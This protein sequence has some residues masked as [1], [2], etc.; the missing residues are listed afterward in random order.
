MPCQNSWDRLYHEQPGYIN[1][2]QQNNEWRQPYQQERDDYVPSSSGSHYQDD[3]YGN[4]YE[5]GSYGDDAYQLYYQKPGANGYTRC[6]S[7]EPY[8]NG[9][10]DGDDYAYEN[11]VRIPK[12][13]PKEHTLYW[14]YMYTKTHLWMVRPPSGNSKHTSPQKQYSNSSRPRNSLGG[15]TGQHYNAQQHLSGISQSV[16]FPYKPQHGVN[17]PGV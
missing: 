11:G 12:V 8:S 6:A 1:G 3:Y 5:E 13:W 10:H 2:Y 14:N 17:I 9:Y 16:R 15:N 4:Y 7:N